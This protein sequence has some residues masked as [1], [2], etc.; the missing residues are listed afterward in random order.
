MRAGYGIHLMDAD[1]GNPDQVTDVGD[2]NDFDFFEFHGPVWSPDGSQ[3]AFAADFERSCGEGVLPDIYMADATGEIVARLTSLSEEG[4]SS[5]LPDW[6]PDGEEIVFV[7]GPNDVMGQCYVVEV[8]GGAPARIAESE[9][10]CLFPAWSP[11]GATIAVVGPEG[12]LLIPSGEGEPVAV[13]LGPEV[14]LIW[15]PSWSPDGSKL[16]FE[17]FP[18]DD[19]A[20]QPALVYVLDVASGR[21]IGI[22][23]NTPFSVAPAW[24]PDGKLIAFV[25]RLDGQPGTDIY[26]VG[27]DGSDPARVTTVG[28]DGAQVAWPAWGPSS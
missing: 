15:H 17:T 24:S 8:P 3:F 13:P 18:T 28:D 20:P 19:G 21:V 27:P 9:P 7:S 26:V 16:L 5:W 23:T 4:Y 2:C 14:T 22:E 12:F 25:G 11:E 6:S 10:R 1:G